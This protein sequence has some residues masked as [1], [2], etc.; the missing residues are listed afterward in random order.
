M[1]IGTRR[2]NDFVMLGGAAFVAGCTSLSGV[3]GDAHYACPAPSG[4]QC[5]SV[6]ANYQQSL[7]REGPTQTPISRSEA[8][9]ES[10]STATM[11]TAG[12]ANAEAARPTP[13]YAP[14]RI[15][16]LWVAP[17]EDRDNVLHDAAFVHVPIDHGHWLIDHVRTATRPESRAIRPPRPAASAAPA[18]TDASDR[19][20]AL[21]RSSSP[22]ETQD[23]DAR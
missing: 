21:P 10:A 8:I 2:G 12:L 23:S 22:V 6:S 13:L 20:S 14:P 3:G 15:L 4:V 7:H 1:R 17:W 19:S 18:Q 16:T 11:T 5:A 9:A